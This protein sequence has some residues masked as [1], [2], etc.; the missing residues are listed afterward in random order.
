MAKLVANRYSRALFD[1]AVEKNI[2]NQIYQQFQNIIQIL[3]SQKELNELWIHPGMSSIEKKSM[4]KEIFEA[5][6]N[7]YLNSFIQ[8]LIDKGREKYINEIFEAYEEL[9]KRH[10][11]I[12]TAY[13]ET[14]VPLTKEQQT[15]LQ[16]RLQ[17]KLGKKI[18][19][20]I[21]V[22]PAVIAGCSVRVQDWFMDGTYVGKIKSV[23]DLLKR[24]QLAEEGV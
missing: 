8:I 22:N 15:L 7:E 4:M 17:N 12:E 23:K 6:S 5:H 20:K 13:V 24:V 10:S 1:L 19:M 14:A 21:T 2:E 3:M 11:N 16:E 18:E 9:F